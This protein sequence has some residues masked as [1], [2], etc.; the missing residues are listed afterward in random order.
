M[1]NYANSIGKKM[2]GGAW[3]ILRIVL[4][5]AARNH[6][7][8]TKPIACRLFDQALSDRHAEFAIEIQRV[9]DCEWGLKPLYD[10]VWE[11]YRRE[12][13]CIAREVELASSKD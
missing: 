2:A 12:Q 10:E 13:K 1:A 7:P 9:A 8:E 6:A 5:V 11:Q 4:I 3:E